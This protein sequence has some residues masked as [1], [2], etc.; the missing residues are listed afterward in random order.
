MASH[1]VHPGAPPDPGRDVRDG[2]GAPQRGIE[3]RGIEYLDRN[4]RKLAMFTIYE[5]YLL[6][7]GPQI[8]PSASARHRL[9]GS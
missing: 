5:P 7:V 3:K 2:W 4:I 6:R 1:L 8:G 9:R